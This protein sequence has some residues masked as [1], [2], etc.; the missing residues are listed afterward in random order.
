MPG[1]ITKFRHTKKA[2]KPPVTFSLAKSVETIAN[3]IIG[4]NGKGALIGLKNDPGGALPGMTR[5]RQ[6]H[7]LFLFTSAT[8]VGRDKLAT[9]S[10]FAKKHLPLAE[11]DY[12]FEIVVSKP[13]WEALTPEQQFAMTYH[14]LL[15]C[16]DNDKGGWVVVPHDLEEF[17]AVVRHFGLW[18]PRVKQMA[19][20]MSLF[21]RIAGVRTAATRN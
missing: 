1:K 4:Y 6:A 21:D 12:A 8:Q 9:A 17:H 3:K 19:E 20:Q 16:G 7:I 15:H 2:P 11:D 14:E 5:L 10:K 18:S 13:G